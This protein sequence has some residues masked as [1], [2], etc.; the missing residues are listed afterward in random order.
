MNQMSWTISSSS[1][2]HLFNELK[3][4]SFGSWTKFNELIIESSSELFSSW[5]NSLS[6]YSEEYCFSLLRKSV[7]FDLDNPFQLWKNHETKKKTQITLRT[8]NRKL[9]Q[10]QKKT[11]YKTTFIDR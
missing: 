1:L 6:P 5:F 9:S 7:T 11:A 4:S 3:F 8:A 2:G 10:L